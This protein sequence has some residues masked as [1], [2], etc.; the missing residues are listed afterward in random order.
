MSKR[1]AETV[2]LDEIL[3]SRY[4]KKTQYMNIYAENMLNDFIQKE[5]PM[6][7]AEDDF[8]LSENDWDKLMKV[9]DDVENNRVQ[10]QNYDPRAQIMK[11]NKIIIINNCS[12]SFH[13]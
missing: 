1:F 6:S 2:D 13:F 8:I 11:D 4:A 12:G 3:S 7:A 9:C 10:P 5:T